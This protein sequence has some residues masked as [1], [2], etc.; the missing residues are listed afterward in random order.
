MGLDMYIRASKYVSGYEHRGE[1]AVG[2]YRSLLTQFGIEKYVDSDSPTA[3][4]EFTVAYWR[5]A[6]HIH[7]WFVQNVQHGKDEC[8]PHYVDRAQ[9]RDLRH[10]CVDLLGVKA[11]CG[12]NPEAANKVAAERLPTQEGFFF[13]NTEYDEWYWKNITDTIAQIDRILAM[14]EEWDLEY[15]S[16]W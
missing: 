1:Q 8:H 7:E 16:S 12:K 11:A 9:L 3:T 10:V 14:P 2:E 4:V 15:Q 5:K 6:N 13:G